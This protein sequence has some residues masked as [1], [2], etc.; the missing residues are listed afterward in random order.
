M[1]E[2]A[3]DYK[4]A[5]SIMT[6]KVI[7]DSPGIVATTLKD[8]VAAEGAEIYKDIPRLVEK[9]KAQGVR[10]SAIKPVELVLYGSSLIR[11]LDQLSN[12][13]SAIDI[14]NIIL[15]AESAGLSARMA[16]KTVS[17][18]LFSL[19]VPQLAQDVSAVELAEQAN[20]GTIYIP[21]AAYTNRIHELQ[22]KIRNQKKLTESDFSE[23]NAFAQAGIPAANSLLGEIYLVGMGVPADK[24]VALEH[25]K[26]AAAHG[27]AEAYGLLGDYYY[28]QDNMK[29]FELYSRPGAMALNEKRWVRFRNLHNVKRYN[30]LQALLLVLLAVVVELFMFLFNTSA[31]TGEHVIASMICSVINLITIAGTLFVHYKNPYQDL[32]NLSLPLLITFFIFAQIYIY[33]ISN[34]EPLKTPAFSAF[35]G[36]RPCP[37]PLFFPSREK[38]RESF[39]IRLLPLCRVA[40]RKSAWLLLWRGR[41]CSS[42]Y[43]HLRVREVPAHP[44]VQLRWIR[45]CWYMYVSTDGNGSHPYCPASSG[46]SGTRC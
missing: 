27:E 15:T 46:M 10:D 16:R 43:L 22:E 32:R 37:F 14:N 41:K 44:W 3:R 5:A 11:Y 42:W 30:N 7:Q 25:L 39:F 45:G 31:I 36:P 24:Q 28:G 1:Q 17:N 29:A 35:S 12:G 19:N 33:L 23:I 26:Y 34:P 4:L 2:L 21:P 38:I 40:L 18:I 6:R 13:L 9:L 8:I 20:G